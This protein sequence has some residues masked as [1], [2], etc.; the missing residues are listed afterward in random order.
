MDG[1]TFVPFDMITMVQTQFWAGAFIIGGM[2]IAIG[3]KK[4]KGGPLLLAT[5]ALAASEYYFKISEY[6]L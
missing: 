4:V 5:C 1:S 6:L 2:A 3:I